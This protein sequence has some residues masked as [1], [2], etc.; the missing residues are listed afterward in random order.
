MGWRSVSMPVS[1]LVM[2]VSEYIVDSAVAP[3]ADHAIARI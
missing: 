1:Y 3:A 2:N